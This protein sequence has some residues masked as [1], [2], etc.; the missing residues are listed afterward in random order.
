MY[1]EKIINACRTALAEAELEYNEEHV[2]KSVIVTF[3]I[4]KS[5]L[6]SSFAVSQD[7]NLFA[8]VWTTTPWTLPSNQAIAYNEELDY[9]LMSIGGTSSVY[10]MASALVFELESLIEKPVT[11]LQ[12]IPG[13]NNT[14]NEE[15]IYLYLRTII[16]FFC[17]FLIKFVEV[18]K[19]F[20]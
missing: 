18:Q 15:K 4:D 1:S 5:T 19:S 13:T 16:L 11:I 20:F 14:P 6:P 7:E 8:L 17:R 3:E 12:T 10:L 9:C 2:S